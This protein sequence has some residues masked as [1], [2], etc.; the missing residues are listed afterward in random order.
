ME[1]DAVV[2]AGGPLFEP[3]ADLLFAVSS[4]GPGL[5]MLRFGPEGRFGGD[6]GGDPT[7]DGVRLLDVGAPGAVGGDLGADLR[8]P[9]GRPPLV[10]S[11]GGGPGNPMV[12][13]LR[14]RLDRFGLFGRV[15]QGAARRTAHLLAGGVIPG[16]GALRELG[17]AEL[18]TSGVAETHQPGVGR[19][20]GC[21]AHPALF[22]RCHRIVKLQRPGDRGRPVGLSTP[23][24][25][26]V[27]GR[28]RRHPAAPSSS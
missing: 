13:S 14:D 3:T 17:G 18:A 6:G 23:S 10:L 8:L 28:T 25:V 2:T 15:V 24:L 19:V 16:F 22:G 21:L 20:R 1:D 7:E 5:E 11:L 4:D 12:E 26:G 27:A 9:P